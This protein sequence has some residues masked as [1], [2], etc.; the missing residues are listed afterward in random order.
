MIRDRA[1][2]HCG[3]HSEARKKERRR[4]GGWRMAEFLLIAMLLIAEVDS[5]L[6]GLKTCFA[7]N[8][9]L[10]LLMTPKSL[11]TN[12]NVLIELVQPITADYYCILTKFTFNLPL[13]PAQHVISSQLE[14][15][16]KRF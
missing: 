12:I 7:I 8:A 4:L 15:A 11:T 16:A 14:C 13:L 1:G 3:A 6:H 5:C 9:D 2:H 10:V